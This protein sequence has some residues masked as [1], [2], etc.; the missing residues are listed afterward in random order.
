MFV[1][2]V[3]FQLFERGLIYLFSQ[4]KRLGNG[5]HD[6]VGVAEGSQRDETDAIGKVPSQF[7]CH[8]QTQARFA[9]ASR[10][11]KCKQVH[12]WALYERTGDLGLTLSPNERCKLY[13]EIK[14]MDFRAR[15]CWLMPG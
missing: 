4:P 5:R 7:V 12:T 1:L 3:Y 10:T 9:N 11:C 13:G 2:Q 8:L 6:K 15:R 14:E